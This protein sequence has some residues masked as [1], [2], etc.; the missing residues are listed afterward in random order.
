MSKN[1]C[2]KIFIKIFVIIFRCY[3]LVVL[4]WCF[5]YF[6]YM[7]GYDFLEIVVEGEKIF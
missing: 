1:I 3:Y 2:R 5:Y 7:I 6:V 4:G